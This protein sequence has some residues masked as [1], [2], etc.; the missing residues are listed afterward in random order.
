MIAVYFFGLPCIYEAV[1]CIAYIH[2]HTS[3]LIKDTM[4]RKLQPQKVSACGT[5]S[6]KNG[7]QQV[8]VVNRSQLLQLDRRHVPITRYYKKS[9]AQECSRDTTCAI[10]RANIYTFCPTGISQLHIVNRQFRWHSLK[11]K[12]TKILFRLGL[13]PRPY[14]APPD[15]Q[16]AF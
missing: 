1:F 12:C 16:V 2:T 8:K 14:N 6:A 7:V 13:R 11:P 5:L 15:P 9:R 3:T 10:G 4:G